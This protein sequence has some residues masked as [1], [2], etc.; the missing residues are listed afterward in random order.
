VRNGQT[1]EL[2]ESWTC[3]RR[4]KEERSQGG[5]GTEG[6]CEQ[7]G[8]GRE[9]GHGARR[10]GKKGGRRSRSTRVRVKE[11]KG[12]RIKRKPGFGE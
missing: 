1:G 8:G 5:E 10:E 4:T 2:R 11:N 3:A 9:G 12:K 6:N 7:G